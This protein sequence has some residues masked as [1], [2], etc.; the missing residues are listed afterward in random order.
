MKK[1][2]AI[3][4]FVVFSNSA[5][6][7]KA[8]ASDKVRNF[9]DDIGNK[10]IKIADDNKLSENQKKDKIIIEID[11]IID[12]DWISR[13]VLGKNYKTANDEQKNRFS[14]LYRQFMI[15]TYG[16]KFKN[17][18]GRGFTVIKVENQNNFYVAKCEFLPKDSNIPVN[19]D[20]RVKDRNNKLAVIDF[21]AEGVSLLETQR[22]E[23][24]A[25]IS[26]KGMDKFMDDLALRVKELKNKK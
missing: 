17:Y 8:D 14:E 5:L 23:F 26:Q 19:V 13:F 15:N 18:N 7:Q 25:A 10:I 24:N 3:F 11:K 1:L 21:V 2:I 22:S 20:F 6:A 4:I 16:P 12:T 9:V